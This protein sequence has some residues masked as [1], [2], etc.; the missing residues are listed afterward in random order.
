MDALE[1][2]LVERNSVILILNIL[3]NVDIDVGRHIGRSGSAIVETL[4]IRALVN[5]IRINRCVA[6]ECDVLQV[7]TKTESTIT[8]R[9]YLVGNHYAGQVLTLIES[10]VPNLGDG[11]RK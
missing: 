2:V 6:E 7:L 10:K 3:A 9:G 8:D 1:L 4:V 5:V 11:R